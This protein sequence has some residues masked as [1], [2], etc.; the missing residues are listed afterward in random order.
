MYLTWGEPPDQVAEKIEAAATVAAA[1]RSQVRFGIRLHV[2]VRET[3]RRPGRRR[4]LISRVDD[5]TIARGAAIF[6]RMDSHGQSRMKALHGGRR[7]KLEISPNLWAG[8]GLVRGGAGT[9]LVGD[10]ETVAERMREYMRSASTPSSSAATRTWKRPTASPSWYSRFCRWPMASERA[11]TAVNGPFGE[12]IAS[13][14]RRGSRAR[15]R[16]GSESAD[17][18]CAH[19]SGPAEL[20]DAARGTWLVPV[21]G[22]S[23]P[24]RPRRAAPHPAP[25]A[26]GA[27]QGGPGVLGMLPEGTLLHDVATS[28]RARRSAS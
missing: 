3:E 5:A 13:A 19:D 8:V 14:E 6:A 22:R 20:D 4:R 9:A 27:N 1:R 25:G 26:A 11:A 28:A 21:A 16:P 17:K 7:E 18:R 2:I 24:G 10:A 23:W 12:I 15:A